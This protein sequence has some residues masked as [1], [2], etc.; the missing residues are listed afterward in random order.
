M[1]LSVIDLKVGVVGII[2]IEKMRSNVVVVK[3]RAG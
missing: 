2:G 1:M 3:M